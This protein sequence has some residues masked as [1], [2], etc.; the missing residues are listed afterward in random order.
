MKKVI[1][2]FG[3]MLLAMLFLPACS[4]DEDL[5]TEIPQVEADNELKE[6]MYA[7]L[8]DHVSDFG[9]EFPFTTS[10]DDNGRPRPLIIN[11]Q[12]DF[13]RS[14]RT[15]ESNINQFPQIDF[16]KYSLVVG[17]VFYLSE[18]RV[19]EK[20]LG[21]KL[22]KS[23]NEYLMELNYAY[24]TSFDVFSTTYLTYWGLYPK[25]DYLPIRSRINYIK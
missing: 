24:Q 15:E 10:F 3:L 21:Q 13:E 7:I 20:S 2:D 14:F 17:M 6:F 12:T 4:D 25:L 1:V 18:K 16:E 11:C 8:P 19:P 23:G 22:Y 9:E 5:R